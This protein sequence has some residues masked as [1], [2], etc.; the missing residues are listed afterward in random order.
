MLQQPPGTIMNSFFVKRLVP[1][2][3][4]SSRAGIGTL[5]YS[6]VFVHW[7]ILAN[8]LLMSY[9]CQWIRKCHAGPCCAWAV[10]VHPPMPFHSTVFNAQIYKYNSPSYHFF[11]NCTLQTVQSNLMSLKVDNSMNNSLS[12]PELMLLYSRLSIPPSP[13]KELLDCLP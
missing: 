1:A 3:I 8:K 13:Y 10:Q 11:V 9:D 12:S 2:V 6:M 7:A 4:T 5:E